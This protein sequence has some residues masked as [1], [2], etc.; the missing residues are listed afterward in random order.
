MTAGSARL[1]LRLRRQSALGPV[2][3]HEVAVGWFR[4]PGFLLTVIK[5]GEVL[6]LSGFGVIGGIGH[7]RERGVER[8]A[9]G[10]LGRVVPVGRGDARVGGGVP[11]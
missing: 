4:G 1:G 3:P 2:Q 5:P 6:V 8:P 10:V 7:D 11:A 9:A